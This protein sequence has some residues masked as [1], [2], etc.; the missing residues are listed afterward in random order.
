MK[1]RLETVIQWRGL[2]T[3][4][5]FAAEIGIK[6][7]SIRDIL[8]NRSRAISG[9]ILVALQLKHRINPAWLLLGSGEMFLSLNTEQLSGEQRKVLKMTEDN[10]DLAEAL[11][12]VNDETRIEL[13][14][15]VSKLD[16]VRAGGLND[17]L[18]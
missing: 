2:P 17:L 16:V 1:E 5:A 11:S 6:E 8:K 7:S 9:A 18:E 3:V 15:K 12:Q 14:I 13:L 4:K 10:P